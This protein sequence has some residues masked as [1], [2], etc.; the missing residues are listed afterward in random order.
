MGRKS[1]KLRNFTTEQIEDIFERD[2]KYLEGVKLHAIIQLC[3]G[4]SSRKL[5]EFYGVSF[6]QICNWADRFDA[7]GI[8]GLRM[9]PGRGRHSY[10]S[11]KQKDALRDVLSKNPAEFGYNAANWTGRTVRE[12]IR[13]SCHVEYKHAAVY[14]IMRKMGFNLRE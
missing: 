6:K 2:S 4:Y 13:R 11:E 3:K 14:G 12:H 1:K 10:L 8:N 7:E 5:S 9:K